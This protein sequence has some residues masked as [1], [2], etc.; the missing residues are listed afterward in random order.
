MSQR[1]KVGTQ[2]GRTG[3]GAQLVDS[4][5]QLATARSTLLRLRDYADQAAVGGDWQGMADEFGLVD[6][7]TAQTVYNLLVGSLAVLTAAGDLDSFIERI[8]TA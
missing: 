5:N 3:T 7:A 4:V 2:Y 1:I 6:A 8:A